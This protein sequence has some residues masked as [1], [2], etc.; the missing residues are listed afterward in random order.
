MGRNL[1]TQPVLLLMSLSLL[2]L[3]LGTSQG[4][5]SGQDRARLLQEAQQAIDSGRLPNA[6][7]ALRRVLESDPDNLAARQA[8]VDVLM[9]L[10]KWEEAE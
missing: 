1:K 6:E 3:S 7:N 8:L 4:E 10:L 2:S 9:R 5:L